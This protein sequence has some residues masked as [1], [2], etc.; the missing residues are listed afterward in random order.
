MAGLFILFEEKACEGALDYLSVAVSQIVEREASDHLGGIVALAMQG[1]GGTRAST[2]TLRV[3]TFHLA[4]LR[5]QSP[6]PTLKSVSTEQP[7][8]LVKAKLVFG[9]D[10]AFL[11]ELRLVDLAAGETFL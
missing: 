2:S 11:F 5:L 1:S 3:T 6:L 9:D 7:P 8:F 10:P 4:R